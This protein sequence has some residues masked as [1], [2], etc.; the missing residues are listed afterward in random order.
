MLGYWRIRVLPIN[1]LN[2]KHL[3]F[4]FLFLLFK[5][6][7]K[8]KCIICY[9]VKQDGFYLFIYF[10]FEMQIRVQVIF[11]VKCIKFQHSPHKE[12]PSMHGMN[13]RKKSR[14]SNFISLFL[15]HPYGRQAGPCQW[16]FYLKSPVL[17]ISYQ[18]N[19]SSFAK[20][21]D[22]IERLGHVPH[23]THARSILKE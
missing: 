10:L 14:S 2:H 3:L 19:W 1:L 4:C 22:R 23:N 9:F 12:C 7:R 17:S 15:H 21:R 18:H 11:H 20:F 13:G 5:E 16:T 8:L 6:K